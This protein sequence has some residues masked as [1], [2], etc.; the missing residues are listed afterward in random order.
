MP[1]SLNTTL[2]LKGTGKWTVFVIYLLISFTGAGFPLPSV[3]LGNPLWLEIINLHTSQTGQ[4]HP[5]IHLIEFA[6]GCSHTQGSL[7]YLELET[8]R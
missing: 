8:K 7:A 3:F 2:R 5:T 6:T 1:N 4:K